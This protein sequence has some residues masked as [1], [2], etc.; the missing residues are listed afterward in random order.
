MSPRPRPARAR[1]FTLIELLVVI[2]IIAVL[3]ALLLPA[4]QAAREA[5]RRMQCTNNLKQLGIALHNY[6]DANNTLPAGMAVTALPNGAFSTSHG[7]FVPLLPYL[8]Q[9]GLYASMN[10]NVTVFDPP[11]STARATGLGALWCP[12]DVGVDQPGAAYGVSRYTSYVGSLGP[13]THQ[14][15]NVAQLAVLAPQLPGLFFYQSAVRLAEVTDGTANTLALGE[16]AAGLRPR[17]LPAPSVA[18]F[19]VWY[20]GDY[21]DTNFQTHFP[22]NPQNRAPTTTA[23]AVSAASSFHPGGCNFA[24]LDGSVRFLKDTIDSW[25]IDRATNLP[26]G[27]TRAA[28]VPPSNA[29]PYAL[30][31]DAR[32]G[33]YQALSTRNGAEVISADSY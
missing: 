17:F 26:V 8:E 14:P 15:S 3:I 19:H 12:S 20:S 6:L 24:F 7:L 29:R 18:F 2:A 5:A 21:R 10:F 1:G 32:L 25:P 11:N 9:P 23:N 22:M 33:V 31:P 30:S 4:V 13:W 16:H 27:V 28:A